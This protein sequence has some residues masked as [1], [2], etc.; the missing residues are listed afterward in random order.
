[1]VTTPQSHPTGHN[2]ALP[3]LDELGCQDILKQQQDYA[4]QQ[5]LP[6]SFHDLLATGQPGP[7]LVV[8]PPGRF[9]MGSNDR[10]FGHKREEYPQHL[11][12]LHQGFAMGCYPLMAEEFALFQQDTEWRRRPEL[13]WLEGRYPVVN[14]RMEDIKVYLEWL[15]AQTGERYRLPTEPEWEY[16]ARAGTSTP[17]SFGQTVSCKE[18]NFNPAFPYQERLEK[19]R[20][21]L[22]RCLPSLQASEVG[23]KAANTWGLYD[24]HGNVWEFTSS[25]WSSSHLGANRDGSP[26]H[27]ADPWW[28]V[29]KGGSWFDSA[30]DARSAA[31]KKRYIDE[32]DIN[33]GFRVVREL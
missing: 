21:Y 19:R 9:E 20:W 24:M 22:P 29:T 13:I 4:A 15:S 32:L 25:H 27:G 3:I 6:V 23:L 33:L 28:Y 12:S 31:R 16:A 11:V 8:I 1:M 18:V 17:F 5:G 7:R 26:N 30:S 10:E 14:V 2:F